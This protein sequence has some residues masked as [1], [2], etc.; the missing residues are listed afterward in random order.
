MLKEKEKKDIWSKLRVKYSTIVTEPF[1]VPCVIT[2]SV[3]VTSEVAASLQ[4][5]MWPMTQT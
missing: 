3:L 4:L 1:L 5:Y 2:M